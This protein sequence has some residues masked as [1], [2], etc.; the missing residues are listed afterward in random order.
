MA[1]PANPEKPS[2]NTADAKGSHFFKCVGYCAAVTA[3]CLCEFY[4][5]LQTM[6]SETIK[7]YLQCG[8]FQS[9]LKAN[10][11]AA[12]LTNMMNRIKEGLSGENLRQ[13]LL[14][15]VQGAAAEMKKRC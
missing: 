4:V 2:K 9:W 1:C 14:S 10:V 3:T 11:G 7:Y 12:E 15:L 5:M 8:D 6:D 13:E